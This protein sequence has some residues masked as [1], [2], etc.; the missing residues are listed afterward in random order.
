MTGASGAAGFL[1]DPRVND[2]FKAANALLARG[3]SVFRFG[4]DVSV[5]D[6]AF[7]AGDRVPGHLLELDR[8]AAA[9]RPLVLLQHGAGG[10]APVA[11]NV[12]S[13]NALIQACATVYGRLDPCSLAML[14]ALPDVIGGRA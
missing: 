4:G 14:L 6:N 11:L 7:P 8:D 3:E 10:H 2:S 13:Y 12:D 9:R 1:F 5:G